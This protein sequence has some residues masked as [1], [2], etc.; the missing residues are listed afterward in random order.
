[1]SIRKANYGKKQVLFYV[2]QQELSGQGIHD[3]WN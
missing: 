2:L 1:L 3:R